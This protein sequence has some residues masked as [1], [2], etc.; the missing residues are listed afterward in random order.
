MMRRRVGLSAAT[1][2]SPTYAR[3][4][5]GVQKYVAQMNGHRRSPIQP[6]QIHAVSIGSEE[7]DYRHLQGI[8]S[9]MEW[10]LRHAAVW[11]AALRLPALAAVTHFF[12]AHKPNDD[13]WIAALEAVSGLAGS[14]AFILTSRIGDERLW[15]EVLSR[16]G[17]DLLLTP[18]EEAEVIHTV[19]A[20]RRHSL[21]QPMRLRAKAG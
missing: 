16:G 14:P 10:E 3:L 13:A 4:A 18:F 8:F 7:F 17:Y 21:R 19:A 20:S 12:F 1:F 15:G 9:T 2:M 11:E 6:A 5:R